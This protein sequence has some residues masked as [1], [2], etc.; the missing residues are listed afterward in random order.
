MNANRLF[1]PV[2]V[3]IL[4]CGWLSLP[5]LAQEKVIITATDTTL[6]DTQPD[7]EEFKILSEFYKQLNGK[8]WKKNTNW[9]KG[10]TSAEMAK[11]YGVVVRNGDVSEI[12]LD[13]NN[14]KGR[15]PKSLYDLYSLVSVSLEGNILEEENGGQPSSA[16]LSTESQ[17]MSMMSTAQLTQTAELAIPINSGKNLPVWGLA[18]QGPNVQQIDWRTTPPQLAN[19]QNSGASQI[20]ASGV[21]IDDCGLLAFYALHS[22]TD[23]ANQLHLYSANGTRLTNT[24]AG[25]A[26]RGL[27]SAN[28]NVELQIVRVPGKADEWFIIYS[29][30]QP[31]CF[32]NPPSS[33][34]CPAKVVY[35]RVKYNATVGLII[36]PAKRE[37]SISN[38]TFT[39]GKA[40]SRTVNGDPARHYLYLAQREIG[41]PFQNFTKI[42]R[43]IIDAVGINFGTESPIQ[44]P[45]KFWVG[46]ISGSSLELSPDETHLALI[47]RNVGAHILEDIIVFDLAQFNSSTYVPN[48]ITVPK[49]MVAG[50]GKSIKQLSTE[51][52]YTCFRFLK[53]RLANLEFS[54]SGRYLYTLHGGYPD[55][56][57]G[58]SYNTYLLQIDLQSGTGDS[59]Y[60]V[61]MQVEKGIGVSTA[62]CQ[63]TSGTTLTNTSAQQIQAAYDGRFYFTKRNSHYLFVIPN[64]DAPLPHNMTPGVIDLSTAQVPNIAMN[65][66]AKVL[67]M[68]ENIDGY[69]YLKESTIE[70]FVLD[71]TLLG[72]DERVLLTIQGFVAPV[73]GNYS[74]QVSWGDGTIQSLTKDTASH[75]YTARGDYKITLTVVTPDKCASVTSKTVKVVDC[76]EMSAMAIDHTAYLCAIKF[77]VPKITDCFA[78][79]DWNFGDGNRSHNR[80]PMHVYAATGTYN[81]S[82]TIKYNCLTCKDD[83]TVTKPVTVTSPGP[84]LENQVIQIPSDQRMR[85]ISSGAASFS[86]AWPLDHNEASLENINSFIG[87]SEGIWRNEG[88]FVYNTPR[89]ASSP[90]AIGT[91]GTYALDYFNWAHSDLEVIPKW[92]KTNSM[93]RYNAYSFELENKD[94][95]NVHSGA[96]YDYNG[97]LQSAHGVSM[98]NEEMGFT[99]FEHFNDKPTGNFIFSNKPLPAYNTYKVLSAYSYIAVVTASLEDL[100]NAEY[101]DISMAGFPS[102]LFF[103]SKKSLYIQ[104]V[105]IMCKEVYPDNPAWSVLVFESAP[106]DGLWVGEIRIKNIIVPTV[107]AVLDN[108]IA[109]TGKTSMRIDAE[110]IFEQKLIQPDSG[111]TYYL[112]AWVSVNNPH[113]LTP[114]LSDRLG[115]DVILK[116]K[117]GSTVSSTSVV[118]EGKIIE[119]WQQVRGSFTCPEK[120]LIVALRFKPGSTGIAWYDDIRFHPENGNLKSY[121][122]NITDYRLSAILDEDNFATFFYY[123][124]EGNLY[125]T[126]KETEDGIKSITENMTYQIE[127]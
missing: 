66:N 34:Y 90:V 101:A 120:D 108:T 78:T 97:Q 121:V 14:L 45:A 67:F 75:S 104:N 70:K 31:P 77:S 12:N 47:N 15:V 119:G 125:L 111:K 92:V 105:K 22:G 13:Q 9:L 39:Q 37:I 55:N 98:R 30:F 116:K 50:T 107:Q 69:D 102:A 57:G 24:T 11:W 109:H 127:R 36:D 5:V 85:I 26:T 83:I 25:S 4:L 27:S 99:S 10:K 44:I 38:K 74:Y 17:S 40:V 68:P 33:I 53:N 82:V 84:V 72:K 73:N 114:K 19:L 81:V 54:P 91:D 124:K 87:G 86:D 112:S 7:E 123:D 79:Y 113:V 59:D 42:H 110:K 122:Y 32:T 56:T 94:V 115:I 48:I 61:R 58:V 76:A 106:Y 100:E 96:L 21:A 29:L 95:L 93:T 23:Q 16:R 103:F 41:T 117:D 71:E 43:F 60:E 46:G 1:L 62:S 28:G 65:A 3:L 88:T 63:G 64:P 89:S 6:F 20:G 2:S 18:V 118:T 51:S 8:K 126:K 52:G 49:L 80:S 35:T